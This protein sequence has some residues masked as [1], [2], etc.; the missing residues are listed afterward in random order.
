MSDTPESDRWLAGY[1]DNA[2]TLDA[3]ATMQGIER[4]R[5]AYAETLRQI[6]SSAVCGGIVR[7]RHPELA[8]EATESP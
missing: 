4:Q 1:D 7:E 6:A 8:Q 3:H 5:D 2:C